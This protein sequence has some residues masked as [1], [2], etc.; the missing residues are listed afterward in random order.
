MNKKGEERRV[1]I[2]RERKRQCE[3]D[4]ERQTERERETEREI[5]RQKESER[6][7]VMTQYFDDV[8]RIFCK[9]RF[10]IYSMSCV[11]MQ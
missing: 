4:G 7:R 9:I 10:V 11:I 6:E 1:G 8:R 5:E 2:E 3:R